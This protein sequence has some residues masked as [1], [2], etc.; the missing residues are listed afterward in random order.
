M[1]NLTIQQI[2]EELDIKPKKPLMISSDITRLWA[3]YRKAFKTFDPQRL[4]ES[5]EERVTKEGT[6]LLPTYS[7]DFCHGEGFHYEHTIP[8]TGGLGRIALKMKGFQRTSHPIYSFAVWGKDAEKLCAMTN[9]SSFGIDS[10]FHYM[11]TNAVDHLMIDLPFTK[12]YTFVHYIEELVGVPYRYQKN[13]TDQYVNKS[14]EKTIRTYSMYVRDLDMDLFY[15]DA[16][17]MLLKDLVRQRNIYY[18]VEFKIINYAD[19]FPIIQND[20]VKNKSRR[21]ATYK[22]QEL[23]GENRR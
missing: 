22:G 1:K 18:G 2:V 9:Q 3:E 4:I 10:P 21:I 16:I 14:G 7:W 20:I 19:S 8:R 6:L 12:G 11:N 17:E 23:D 15:T 5:L 13:F